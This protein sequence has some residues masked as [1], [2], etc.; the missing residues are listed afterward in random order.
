[1]LPGAATLSPL[2]ELAGDRALLCLLDDARRFDRSSIDALLFAV[3]RLHASPVAT[4]FAAG[5]A[6]APFPA[7]GVES[8]TLLRLGARRRSFRCG[9]RAGAEQGRPV[10]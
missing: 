3:R 8:V 9:R 6:E 7:P 5:T 4:I 1:M 10:R 2:S